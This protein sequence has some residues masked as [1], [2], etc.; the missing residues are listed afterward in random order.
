MQLNDHLFNVLINILYLA[1]HRF[2]T[3]RNFESLLVG[4]FGDYVNDGFLVGAESFKR[5]LQS[6]SVF[7][8]IKRSGRKYCR[9]KFTRRKIK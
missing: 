7:C 1:K 9:L 2:K 3:L 5:L 6:F 8:G 4:P